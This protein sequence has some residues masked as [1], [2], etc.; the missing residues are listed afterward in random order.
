MNEQE[1][2]SEMPAPGVRAKMQVHHVEVR[3]DKTFIRMGAVWHG[4][5][6]AQAE[7]E[8][9]IF[10]TA[11]PSAHLEM[12]I[13]NPDAAQYFEEGETYYL[14]FTSCRLVR[15]A[16]EAAA[17]RLSATPPAHGG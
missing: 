17:P 12:H 13:A 1:R 2:T 8:N 9:A 5:A 4:T 11:T 16:E 10:G 7:S 6:E 3:G 15:A 14:D